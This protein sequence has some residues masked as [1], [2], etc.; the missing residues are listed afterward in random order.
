MRF[1]AAST[2]N[3]RDALDFNGLLSVEERSLMEQTQ[4]YCRKSL[5]PRVIEAYRS[6]RFDPTLLPELGKMGL[7]GAPYEGYGCAGTTFVGYGL[8]AR[9]VE[10]I[11]SGYRS[12]VSVQTSLVI[13]PIYNYGSE[14]Q[15]KK[16]IPG[17]A[18]GELIGCFGLTEPNH[19]SNPAGMETKARWDGNA[20]VYKLSGTKSWISNS[21]VA[22]VMIVWA[23]SDRHDNEIMGFI[24][25][26]GM[27]GL[28]T[29][30]IEGKLS[31][32]TS[33]TGQI[34]MDEVPVPEENLLPNVKGIV[35]P[36][37]CLNNARLSIAWGALGAARTCFE[38]ARDYALER[39]VLFIVK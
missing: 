37:G 27:S 7:L 11:D 6:E 19:G 29:P 23:R 30:K 17:L 13:G 36:F 3:Y 4:E 25:E 22:D 15:K 12:T 14:A 8:L 18:A 9:E 28:T 16:Y 35:G 1:A 32:R 34:A 38:I 21:P 33:V 2:F 20:K 39:F 31:L 24:L 5:M 26:R 10:A